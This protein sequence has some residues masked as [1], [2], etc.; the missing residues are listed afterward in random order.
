[1]ENFIGNELWQ[2]IKKHIFAQ[3]IFI[4]MATD[5]TAVCTNNSRSTCGRKSESI[6]TS[7]NSI[8]MDDMPKECVTFK[9]FEDE[10]F[11]QLKKRYGKL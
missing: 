3:D 1:V 4:A 11:R 5:N 9:E 10:F 2:I 8:P 6:R 7:A